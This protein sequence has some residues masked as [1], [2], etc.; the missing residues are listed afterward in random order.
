MLH[1]SDQPITGTILIA[2][3]QAANRELLE[4][5]L[6]TQGRSCKPSGEEV[7]MGLWIWGGLAVVIVVL[8]II[9]I[10]RNEFPDD[11]GP[12]WALPSEH[13]HGPFFP[14][15]LTSLLVEAELN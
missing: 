8:G 15:V 12:K 4:E 6:T 3:D 5:L 11:G 7:W 10:I 2:D 1:H 9:L 13:G 14:N